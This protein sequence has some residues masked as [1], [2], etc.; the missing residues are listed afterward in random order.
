MCW[1]AVGNG[2]WLRGTYEGENGYARGLLIVS[3]DRGSRTNFRSECVRP[4]D[5]V[6]WLAELGQRRWGNDLAKLQLRPGPVL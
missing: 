3:I 1:S 2:E 4:L 5:A 6:E